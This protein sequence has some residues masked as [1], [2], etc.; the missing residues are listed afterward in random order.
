VTE[1][2]T[3]VQAALD[4]EG[5]REVKA[6]SVHCSA[7]VA[8]GHITQSEADRVVRATHDQEHRRMRQEVILRGTY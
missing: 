4:R 5:E 7:A 3:V 6:M 8:A 2:G 1:S